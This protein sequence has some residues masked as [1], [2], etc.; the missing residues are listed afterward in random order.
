[1]SNTVYDYEDVEMW[2][3]T[4]WQDER[5]GQEKRLLKYVRFS[6]N[7]LNFDFTL[8]VQP[9][10]SEAIPQLKSSTHLLLMKWCESM[11]SIPSDVIIKRKTCQFLIWITQ[12]LS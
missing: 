12:L 11:S 10:I 5:Y 8:C 6:A 7:D 9:W 4:D 2:W 3:A 1:M